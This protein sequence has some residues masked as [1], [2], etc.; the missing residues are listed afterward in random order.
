MSE[1]V[2]FANLFADLAINTFMLC[3]SPILLHFVILTI[4]CTVILVITDIEIAICLQ[5]FAL[6]LVVIENVNVARKLSPCSDIG[7][8]GVNWSSRPLRKEESAITVG[9][10]SPIHHLAI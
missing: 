1:F 2:T 10:R 5:S 7:V 3:V 8:A 9:S 6:S 4:S